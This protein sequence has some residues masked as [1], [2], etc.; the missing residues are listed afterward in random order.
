MPIKMITPSSEIDD[1]LAQRI[2]N[3][4]RAVI[5]RLQYIGELVINR[6]R[7]AGSYQ[8][9]TGNLRSSTGYVL[10]QDGRI[11]SASDYSAVKHTGTKG[12]SEGKDFAT[13]LA[14]RYRK[15][16]VLIV[17]AGMS[18]AYYVKKRGYDVLDSG[19]LLA[20]NLVPKMLRSLG[21]KV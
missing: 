1:Y 15:G 16:I 7:T 2:D 20:E 12:G 17:V 18:Y 19:E 21:F 5:Y 13:S 6:V 3:A 8:D 14:S 4:E 11:I 10:V 9:Q